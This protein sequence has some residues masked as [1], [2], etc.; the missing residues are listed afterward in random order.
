MSALFYVAA[1]DKVESDG[2]TINATVI[3][4]FGA[5]WSQAG[6]VTLE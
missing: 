4:W 5:N 1:R 6:E 3:T 2:W